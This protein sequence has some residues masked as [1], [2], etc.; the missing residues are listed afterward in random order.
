[1]SKRDENWAKR[2]IELAIENETKIAERDG[3]EKQLKTVTE[4]LN[5]A[6]RAYTELYGDMTNEE[7]TITRTIFNSLVNRNPLTPITGSEEEFAD[8]SY[9][10][11]FKLYQNTRYSSLFKEVWDDGRTVFHDVDRVICVSPD[12]SV[13]FTNTFVSQVV[14]K[15]IPEL[16]FPYIPEKFITIVEELYSEDS[17]YDA[18][19]ILS[20][21]TAV[22]GKM[23]KVADINKY[24]KTEDEQNM[25]EI[26]VD[27]YVEMAKTRNAA[28]RIKT[29]NNNA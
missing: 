22:N 20:V 2:E 3:L 29:E 17:H 27:E 26:S 21:S 12:N 1:M 11:E 15:Y 16:T 25:E 13:Q 18:I 4:C 10:E 19:A 14:E 5:K 6:L 28:I 8:V 23:E 24:Y 7:S 9:S